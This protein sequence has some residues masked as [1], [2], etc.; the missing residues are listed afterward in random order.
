MII[1][2]SMIF[3]VVFAIKWLSTELQNYRITEFQSNW[4]T[5]QKLE[6]QRDWKGKY[7]SQLSLSKS[8]VEVKTESLLILIINSPRNDQNVSIKKIAE[9][10]GSVLNCWLNVVARKAKQISPID[11]IDTLFLLLTAS[12]NQCHFGPFQKT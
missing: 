11:S 4:V 2:V 9:I 5:D 8:V 10:L 12:H 3:P 6:S 7:V 1:A